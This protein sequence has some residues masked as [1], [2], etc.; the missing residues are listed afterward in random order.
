M[1]RI[2]ILGA[3]VM[4]SAM[5]LPAAD[6][7]HHVD[8]IGTHL[9]EEII[10]SVSGN[11]YH[12]RLK[13]T[14][15]T[16]VSPGR[17]TEFSTRAKSAD[18]IVLGIASAGV[19]WAIDLLSE[20][21]SSPTPVLMVTKG[22]AIKEHTLKALP[23]HVASVLNERLGLKIPVMAIAGPA[24]AGE[25]AAR[26]LTQVVFTGNDA[27]L[28]ART[29]ALFETPYYSRKTSADIIGVEVCAAFKNFYALGVG[30]AQGRQELADKVENDARMFNAAAGLFAQAL[31]EMAKLVSTLGGDPA[32]VSG[33]A[34][35]GDLYV[36]CQAGRNNRMGR[37]LGLGIPYDTAKSDHMA[38]D[39]VE[40]GELATAVGPTLY[41]F[42]RD[43]RLKDTTMPLTCAILNS[44]CNN[45]PFDPDWN[46]FHL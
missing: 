42:F 6:A 30:T 26:H 13:V 18:L 37:L 45:A 36:T 7:G 44:V 46:Q 32:T 29:A 16:T 23:L 10:R 40:G 2:A 12:P 11:G 33:L 41:G 22:M 3:G 24:I 8:L 35:A 20:A 9:D 4:G 28:V 17:W 19:E 14:L 34:G 25:Q 31:H 27:D 38:D 21:L 1:A 43:G 15:P 39:T 5:S